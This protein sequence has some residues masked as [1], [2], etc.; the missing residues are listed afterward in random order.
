MEKRCALVQDVKSSF[1]PARTLKRYMVTH[2][3]ERGYA[4]EL[5]Q[6]RL[7]CKVIW[8]STVEW[9]PALAQGVGS[10]LAEQEFSCP[11]CMHCMHCMH[12]WYCLLNFYYLYYMH[13]L[14]Y[15]YYLY[16]CINCIT[17][18]RCTPTADWLTTWN[19]EML[20]H[21]KKTLWD[22]RVRWTRETR[23]ALSKLA[24]PGWATQH[25]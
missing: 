1:L 16:Q 3:K 13:N 9:R 17:V 2:S 20:A 25:L 23:A 6:G 12:Y 22:A 24:S 7:V 5:C 18:L 11:H 15:M 14:Y 21:L 19:Q 8:S 4:C 10:L